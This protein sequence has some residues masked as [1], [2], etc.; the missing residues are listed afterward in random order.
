MSIG[1]RIAL[2]FGLVLAILVL[3]GVFSYRGTAKLTEAVA[4]GKEATGWVTHTHE[5]N[6][7]LGRLLSQLEEI[8]TSQRGYLLTGNDK[9]LEPYTNGKA[10]I[11]SALESLKDLTST[12]P[13]QQQRLQELRPKIQEK[14][15]VLKE[16]IDLSK[17]KGVEANQAALKAKLDEGRVIMDEIRHQIAAMQDANKELLQTRT[18]TADERASEAD[19]AARATF[20]T[21]G[22]GTAA[23]LAIVAVAGF[24]LTRSITAPVRRLVEGTEK[25]GKGMLDHRLNLVRRDEIGTLAN[26]FDRMTE[27]RQ[28]AH[29]AIREAVGQLSS[30]AAEILA[31]T[32][33]QAAGA[34][35]QA[36]AVSETVATVDEVTQTS[37][38]ASQRAKGV[39]EA[40][41]RALDV[42]KEGR[43]VVG[44]SQAALESV[45]ERVES[46]AE[47]VLALAG[48]AQAIGEI[49]ATVNDI[50]EQ[51]NLLALNAAIEASRAGEH[52]RGFAVVA[53]EVKALAD[54][55]KRST[56]QVRQILTDIQKATNAAV[57]STEDVTKGVAAATRVA[58]QAGEA[59]GS[60]AE[61]L[62]ETAQAAA[63]IVASAGQQAA[64]MAQIHQAMKN[65]DQVARQNLA[66]MRQA[67]QAAQNLNALGNQLGGL[68]G[69]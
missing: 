31:S 15:R 17:A 59:I 66:A 39:G 21:I 35:E 58:G 26:A 42:G 19:A 36:A 27:K 7:A 10:V 38:Q 51:T 24:L 25:V 41:Q 57:L 56:A 34:Q 20:W 55:S 30:S 62:Q 50:A 18:A 49:I 28:E 61:T 33:Q 37:D 45:K 48:Q 16:G 32:T 40:V 3:V 13:A 47:T 1:K 68:L 4:A 44:D 69:K 8:E 11:D 60:L 54:Q 12:V 29:N 5:V 46:T 65:I 9:Y 64:G 63:Q 2:T 43:R 6:I 23:A 52:G 14:W 53:G 22:L 67:E